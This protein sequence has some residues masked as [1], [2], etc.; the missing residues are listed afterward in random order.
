MKNIYG[1]DQRGF[2]LAETLVALGVGMVM[3]LAIYSVVN[4]AQKSTTGI[5]R[6]VVAQQDVRGALQ[7][8]ALE[9]RMVS[10]SSW[11]DNTIWVNPS[12]CA[13][14]EPPTVRRGLRDATADALTIEM[15]IDDDHDVAD[16]NA[17]S[18]AGNEIIRYEYLPAQTDQRI[19]RETISCDSGSR[20]SSGAQP[21]LG[22]SASDPA[23]SGVRVI[24]GSL[25]IP[26][27]RYFD[28]VGTEVF[29]VVGDQSMV[30][31]IRRID[32]TIAVET[33]DVD[34]GTN[35]KRK[36][37]YGTNIILKN[38]GINN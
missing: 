5:E 9:I 32:I 37:I 28:G 15:D 4:M 2:T 35:Q 8:M 34:P 6:K 12:T 23:S 30:P 10:Y 16:D 18:N 13:G 11:A 1:K 14:N 31:D 27:F 38:H 36:L 20:D 24:N 26:L 29:P 19:T 3:L 33:A 7:V 17:G 25:N 21:F 22:P